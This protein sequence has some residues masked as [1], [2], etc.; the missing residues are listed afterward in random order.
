MIPAGPQ[1]P[2]LRTNVFPGFELLPPV[3]QAQLAATVTG[4]TAGTPVPGSAA[5]VT[6]VPTLGAGPLAP[7]TVDQLIAAGFSRA[8]LMDV[9]GGPGSDDPAGERRDRQEYRDTMRDHFE[10]FGAPSP[11]DAGIGM[12]T[13][14]M[15]LGGNALFRETGAL[16]AL[17]DEIQGMFGGGQNTGEPRSIAGQAPPRRAPTVAN[18]VASSPTY[19]QRAAE[20]VEAEGRRSRRRPPQSLEELD[21]RAERD[22]EEEERRSRQTPTGPGNVQTRIEQLNSILYGPGGGGGGNQRGTQRPQ[23]SRQTPGGRGNRR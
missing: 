8:P 19:A 12:L 14:G 2:A 3:T 18:T 23:A 22:R 6:P 5:A 21:R 4:P 9:I 20:I 1:L 7:E 13:A 15:G 11:M 16:D 17:W 10:R